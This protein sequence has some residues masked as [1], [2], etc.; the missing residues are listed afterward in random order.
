ML[1]AAATTL[2][3]GAW[4][5]DTPPTQ[6]VGLWSDDQPRV[7]EFSLAAELN[8]VIAIGLLE[9]HLPGIGEEVEHE[10]V[11][12]LMLPPPVAGDLVG[13]LEGGASEA[14]E[15]ETPNKVRAII[16]DCDSR[17]RWLS[18]ILAA[19]GAA[20]FA[21]ADPSD[22]ATVGDFTQILTPA[23]GSAMAWITRDREGFRQFL[24]AGGATGLV[25]HGIKEGVDKA[26]PDASELN[27]FPSGHTASSF[28]GAA[29]IDRR[30]GTKWGV[31]AYVLATYTGF[32]RVNAERHFLDDVISGMSIGL[33]TNWYFT[34]PHPERVKLN[35]M[36]AEGGAGVSVQIATSGRASGAGA[37]DQPT[38]KRLRWRYEWEF[39]GAEVTKNFVTA[40]RDSGDTIDWRF[41]EENNPTVTA[42]VE[43]AYTTK[44]DHELMLRATPFEVRD[45]GT[46]ENDTDLDGVTFPAG[47][48]LRS[49]YTAYDFRFRWSYDLVGSQTFDLRVGAGASAL[50]TF[51]ELFEIP[52]DEDVEPE[53]IAE[54]EDWVF[55]PLAHLHIGFRSGIVNVYAEADGVEVSGD[56]YL[57]FA[58]MVRFQLDRRWDVGIGYRRIEREVDTEE[59]DNDLRREQ[60]A[61]VFGYR[62]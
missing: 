32:S 20:I 16:G 28:F 59:L 8:R 62:F 1:L 41:D 10:R 23:A 7:A 22:A 52:E 44:R 40:P 26:R 13:A 49:N 55:M 5:G 53:I 37:A 42:H 19:G 17:C 30:Y 18:A 47:E 50:D 33:M 39:G 34:T 3:T 35:P 31:P 36:L 43:L 27:S 21:F 57:D 45:F 56:R 24:Y 15:A 54:V 9:E 25:V 61:L 58:A 2:A 6:D 60:G 38:E 14:K 51:F 48:G 4:A 29:F 11:A 46:F 12:A